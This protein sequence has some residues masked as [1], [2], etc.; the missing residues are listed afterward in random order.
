METLFSFCLC[1]RFV[2][3]NSRDEFVVTTYLVHSKYGVVDFLKYQ[4]ANRITVI[5]NLE[6][7]N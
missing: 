4:F 7:E 5:F 3:I 6:K 1:K 2:A